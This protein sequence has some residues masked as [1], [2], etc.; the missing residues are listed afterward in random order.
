MRYSDLVRVH[1]SGVAESIGNLVRIVAAAK[2]RFAKSDALSDR[3][4]DTIY[5]GD[6]VGGDNGASS[7]PRAT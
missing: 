3:S 7:R 5:L 6:I 1:G 2:C 4:A